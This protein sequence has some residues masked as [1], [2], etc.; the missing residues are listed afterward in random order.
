[1]WAKHL[2]NVSHVR[3]NFYLKLKKKSCAQLKERES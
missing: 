3:R 2:M 1:M